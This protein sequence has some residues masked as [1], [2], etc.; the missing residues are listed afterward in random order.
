MTTIT[1]QPAAQARIL[2]KSL[3]L[4]QYVFWVSLITSP[5]FLSHYFISPHLFWQPDATQALLQS[6]WSLDHSLCKEYLPD[7]KFQK[8]PN[9]S[10]H[11]LGNSG[12][13]KRFKWFVGAVSRKQTKRQIFFLTPP[14]ML[15]QQTPSP[16]WFRIYS[17]RK[18]LE[19]CWNAIH[20]S[21]CFRTKKSYKKVLEFLLQILS[22]ASERTMLSLWC[23]KGQL[24]GMTGFILFQ[25]SSLATDGTWYVKLDEMQ[26]SL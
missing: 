3:S 5:W 14:T 8:S 4:S 13:R 24:Q 21:P 19:L 20:E 17:V 26:C 25:V 16:N 9:F 23:P 6:S 1:S 18:F 15:F 22:V 11:R 10:S 2:D 12:S 7:F